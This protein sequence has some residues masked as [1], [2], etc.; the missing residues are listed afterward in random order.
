MSMGAGI[1]LSANPKGTF[2]E[3]IIYGTPK[4]G[5]MM[6]VRAT[7]KVSGRL[8]FEVYTPGASGDPRCPI[9]LLPDYLQGALATDAYVTGTRGFL[10]VP[11][12]GEELNIL[13]KDV[14][15]T[16]DTH[17]IGDRMKAETGSGK[18]IVEATSA[19]YAPFTLIEA[20]TT[21]F[22]ADGLLGAMFNG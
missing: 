19:N 14:A 20:A 4:P 18:F 12:N 10:Y 17:A 6:Q 1:I 15:G 7:A 3:G 11:A 22:T 9:I 21:A 13:V 16:G 8:T 2:L 5:T